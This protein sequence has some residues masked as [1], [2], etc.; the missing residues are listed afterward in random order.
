LAVLMAARS[1]RHSFRNFQDHAHSAGYLTVIDADDPDRA[2][3][4]SIQGF[5][6]TD[7]LQ[8]DVP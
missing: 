4:R 7:L 5:L 3:A 1:A 2:T 8:R 6:Y